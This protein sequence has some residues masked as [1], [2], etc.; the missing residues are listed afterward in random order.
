[1]LRKCI[2][3]VLASL[4]AVAGA[5]AQAQIPEQDVIEQRLGSQWTKTQRDKWFDNALKGRSVKWA[6][7][8]MNVQ[9]QSYGGV[10]VE[11]LRPNPRT[12][13]ECVISPDRRYFE[14]YA[15]SLSAGQQAT[16]TGAV[17][18][19]LRL[20]GEIRLRVDAEALEGTTPR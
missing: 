13:F 20:Y 14:R 6:G 19:Y 8:V 5:A 9:R 7:K 10:I 15:L 12:T 18:G 1:M 3:P 11:I 4:V 17:S 2:A 16:C